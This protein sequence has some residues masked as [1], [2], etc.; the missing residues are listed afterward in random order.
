MIPSMEDVDG[1]LSVSIA[2][3]AQAQ[4]TVPAHDLAFERLKTV[5]QPMYLLL[6]SQ[7]LMGRL[8]PRR[9]VHDPTLA[10]QVPVRANI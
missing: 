3:T 7:T 9:P 10:L 2:H 6:G 4:I 5:I 8:V 1:A